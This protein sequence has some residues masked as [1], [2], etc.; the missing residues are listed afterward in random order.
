M[1][2]TATLHRWEDMPKEMLN[3]LLGR[4]LISTERMMLA[5]VYLEQGCIVP[6]HSHENEQLT[7]ILEGTLRFWL[8]DD[9]SEVVDVAAGEVLHLPS[10]LPHKAEALDDHARRRHLLPA[11]RGL[12]R[13]QRRLPPPVNLGLAGRVALVCG[14][15]RGLGRAVAEELAAE[16]AAVALCARTASVLDETAAAIASSAA[17]DVLAVAADLSVAGEPTRVVERCLERFG[18]LDVLVTNSG[19]P[20]PGVFETLGPA[21]WE[22]ATALLLRAPVELAAAALPGMKSRGWGRILCV[23]SIAAKQ[24]VENLMLSNSL[25]AAVTGFAKTLARETAKDGV[26][27]NTILPATPRPSASSSCSTRPRTRRRRAP[28]SCPRS[29][30]AASGSRRSS[31]ASR[32]SSSPTAPATSPASRS[33]STAAGCAGSS[34]RRARRG[35]ASACPWRRARSPLR[36]SRARGRRSAPGSERPSRA[37]RRGA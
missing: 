11:A 16:G 30:W 24:P 27:V 15:S 18:R 1:D 10:W 21:D 5:H 34:R 35:W 6:K 29:R 22:H 36:A 17:A 28:R 31:R 26:T 9:E 19:G 2:S 3:P 32:R 13:R 8:G 37:S 33:P 23:T 4:R 12:A 25:R 14:S 7:Y 20:K